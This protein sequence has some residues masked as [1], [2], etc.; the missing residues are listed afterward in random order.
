[1]VENVKVWLGTEPTVPLVGGRDVIV[2]MP[3]NWRSR[4]AV[5]LAYD[6]PIR[7]PIAKGDTLGKLTVAGAGVPAL[8]V[9]L[10]AGADVPKLSLP[11]RAM[12]VL[13]HYVTGS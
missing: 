12:A 7:A 2:T 9:P 11:G 3:R 8:E 5:K 10:L 4:A 1:V 13:S 6:A